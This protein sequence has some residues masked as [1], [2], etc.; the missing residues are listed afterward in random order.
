MSRG[1]T[2]PAT[3]LPRL[4]R[5]GRLFDGR[6]FLAAQDLRTDRQGRVAEIGS[7]LEAA[8]EEIVDLDGRW[9]LPGLVDCHV[10]FR[11][12]GL[13]RK[14]G[15]PTGT[16]GALHGGV[17][18]V[19]EIQNNPPLVTSRALLEAKLAGREGRSHAD[20]GCYASLVEESLLELAAMA[21]RT[22]AFKCFLGCSTGAAGV[23]DEAT[24]RR[25]FGAAAAAG[26]KVVAHC[27]DNAV[28][29]RVAATLTP[30]EQDRHDL[31]RPVEAEVASIRDAV[32]VAAEV[33]LALH[34]FHVSSVE[35]ARLV[36]AAAAS[37]QPVTATTA[38]H[39]LL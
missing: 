19:L 1:A 16:A 39:Y 6:S 8:G 11:E 13:E 21:P 14:E 4:F 22:P 27:E 24:L 20:Y 28:M 15:Y 34:V 29:E 31:R 23:E 17:T 32:R 7:G 33:G 26:V 30:S 37:G 3:P 12:P 35:G 2:G 5:G 36:A 10:H 9:L 25:W 18:T 38:P